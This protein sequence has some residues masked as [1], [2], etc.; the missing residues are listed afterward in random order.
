VRIDALPGR[1][2]FD[3]S[4]SSEPASPIAAIAAYSPQVSMLLRPYVPNGSRADLKLV[5]GVAGVAVGRA[6]PSAAGA[7]VSSAAPSTPSSM[8]SRTPPWTGAC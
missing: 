1:S 6:V 3:A 4:S 7:G 8:L 5:A 2:C